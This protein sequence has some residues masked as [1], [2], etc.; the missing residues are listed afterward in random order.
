MKDRIPNIETI[1]SSIVCCGGRG[2][3]ELWKD[4]DGA[5]PWTYS[6]AFI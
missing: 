1:V 4:V 2:H 3:K 6:M 5:T